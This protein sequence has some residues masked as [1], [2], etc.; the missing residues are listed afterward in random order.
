MKL[1]IAIDGP[2][3]A[4]KSTVAKRVAERLNFLY[5]D[6]GSMYRAVTLKGLEL[7]IDLNNEEDLIKKVINKFPIHLSVENGQ[8]R[9]YIGEFDV[10]EAIREPRI[11]QHVSTVAAHAKVRTAMVDIQR[12][13]ASQ[14]N[15]VMDGRDIGTNVLPNAE[16]KIFLT[17]SIEERA[18]R[19][20]E[21]L[22]NK[23][24]HGDL[25]KIKDEIA[26]RDKKDEQRKVAPLKKAEDAI[27]LDTTHLSIEEAVNNIVMLV[28]KI[29]N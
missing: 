21:E 8:Q 3:G 2:A 19:R 1:N 12:K 29:N 28:T 16:V 23:G 15:V 24:Y 26:V 25:E 10:T 4:G 17:A 5:V 6:T 27:L 22:K 13:L 14:G 9:V 11:S 7:N 20:Y 18:K